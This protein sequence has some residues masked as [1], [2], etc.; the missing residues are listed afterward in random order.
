MS[1]AYMKRMG[2]RFPGLLA[3]ALAL[4]LTACED[5]GGGSKH[6]FGDNDPN[7]VVA[8]G[9]SITA[10]Y[11]GGMVPYPSLLASM[12]GKTVVNA[13]VSG[14]SSG[15]GAS[16]AGGL[17]RRYR[18]GYLLIMLGSNDA[19]MGTDIGTTIERLRGIIGVARAQQ[20]IPILSTIP[21]MY[22]PHALFAG[23]AEALNAAIRGLASQEKV[24]L[25]NAGGQL[26]SEAY[27]VSDGLHPN[28]EGHQR[29]AKAFANAF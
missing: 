11:P 23:N 16:R 6:D 13:G 17:L 3:I 4:G 1:I 2:R 22:G 29:I 26:S 9:D 15:Q 24:K 21:P 7:V 28:Q 18:P 19:I 5:G 14:I 12:I 10:G 27:F 25:V 20:T 8:L